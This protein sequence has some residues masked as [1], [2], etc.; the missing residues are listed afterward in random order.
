[1]NPSWTCP[2][3]NQIATI[4]S[5]NV[6]TSRHIF[7]N[8][9]KSGQLGLKTQVV[10]CPN[11]K[12]REYV[13]RASLHAAHPGYGGGTMLADEALLAWSLKPRSSAKPIPEYVPVSIKQDY[14]EACLI[15]SLSPKASATL[16]RRCLQGMI[17][18]FWGIRKDRLKDEIDGL[19][20]RIAASTWR[21]IDAVRS[22]G[23]IGAHMEKDIDVI[24]DVEP[25]EA[26]L[27]ITLIESLIEDWYVQRNDRNLNMTA[28][29]AAAQ[30]KKDAKRT[31]FTGEAEKKQS[32][33]PRTTEPTLLT[34]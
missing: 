7:D 30:A 32:A 33:P 4:T 28:V 9:N 16:S 1:M 13:L 8:D 2:Y 29:I 6:S 19:K 21:A 20:E 18:D 25:S 14:E 15:V 23:N 27:L 31:E 22:I 3:C 5:S 34:S 11:S 24:V 10:V 12:C 17:R 26:E